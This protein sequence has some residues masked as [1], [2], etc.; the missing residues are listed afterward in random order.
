MD[1]DEI[2]VKNPKPDSDAKDYVKKT[3]AE[4]GG[5]VHSSQWTGWVPGGSCGSSG[6]LDDSVF[7]VENVRILGR[8]VQ[9]DAPTKCS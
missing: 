9:G 8:V 4:L 1:G 6:K 5:Q 3:M 2:E 7:Y